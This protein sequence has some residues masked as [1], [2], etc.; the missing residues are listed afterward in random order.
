MLSFFFLFSPHNTLVLSASASTCTA[1]RG[2][3]EKRWDVEHRKQTCRPRTRTI[4]CA[5]HFVWLERRGRERKK[6]RDY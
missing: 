6:Q 1:S 2:I 3:G 5:A 4:R